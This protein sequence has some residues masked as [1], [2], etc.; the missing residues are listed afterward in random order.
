MMDT[1]LLS[2]VIVYSVQAACV[3]TIGGALAAVVRIDAADVRYFYWRALLALCLALPWLQARQTIVSVVPPPSPLAA[4]S[5]LARA[6]VATEVVATG[7]S[8]TDWITVV[9]WILMAGIVFRLAS[10]A[11]GFWRLRRLRTAGYL[12]PRCDV[13]DEVQQLVRTRAEVRYV[14]S[15]QP[16]TFGF[17]RPVVLLPEADDLAIEV[18]GLD[19][20]TAVIEVLPE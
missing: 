11:I 4:A 5:S 12:A 18:V 19:L 15:G 10:L 17:R 1:S 9:G 2:D 16:V 7:A 8:S 6:S 13:H 3:V 14:A 20:A